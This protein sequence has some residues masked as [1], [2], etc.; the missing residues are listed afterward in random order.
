MEMQVTQSITSTATVQPC[1]NKN[2]RVEGKCKTLPGCI[3][4]AAEQTYVVNVTA[5]SI[6]EVCEKVL[7]MG[8][9]NAYKIY[10]VGNDN[11]SSD[12][13]P[14]VV[15]TS[16]DSVC[17]ECQALLVDYSQ[18]IR[19]GVSSNT[20]FFFIPSGVL[21]NTP[22]T[23]NP[24]NTP[25]LKITSSSK[26]N[27]R[28][29][30]TS[31]NLITISIASKA[32]SSGY[33]A[34]S[35]GFI[36]L[37][38]KSN[39]RTT[40]R[41]FSTSGIITASSL[42][43]VTSASGYKAKS[44]GVITIIPLEKAKGIKYNFKSSGVIKLSVKTKFGTSWH[45]VF[46]SSGTI[47]IPNI[48]FRTAVSYYRNSD[49]VKIVM[50]GSH[51]GITSPSFL[52][53]SKVKMNLIPQTRQIRRYKSS[54]S[55]SLVS[56]TKAFSA[57]L[58]SVKGQ[59]T[60]KA[61]ARTISPYYYVNSIVGLNLVSRTM[62]QSSDL[63]EMQSV[64]GLNSEAMNVLPIFARSI[65]SEALVK[66]KFITLE[67]KYCSNPIPEIITLKHNIKSCVKSF[68]DFLNLNN[69]TLSSTNNCYYKPKISGWVY[70]SHFS[71]RSID[72]NGEESWDLMISL[73]PKNNCWNIQLKLFRS[74]QISDYMT[75]LTSGF[76][77]NAVCSSS[78]GPLNFNYVVKTKTTTPHPVLR[79]ILNDEN[80][81][82]FSGSTISLLFESIGAATQ[83]S[84]Y[85]IPNELL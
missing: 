20:D 67:S 63:G 8:L 24:K 65:A 29:K 22:P 47:K 42:D 69:L 25:K 77:K 54:G 32:K 3:P 30:P 6:C 51:P 17:L 35:K 53:S 38:I 52:I 74:N 7:K 71:G 49:K 13:T 14:N 44:K 72:F 61:H 80:G 59:I 43:K 85:A 9:W 68:S 56:S 15:G 1:V 48:N 81:Y 83:F 66:R 62:S 39:A 60:I 37:S 40:V 16:G 79:T 41:R 26:S 45:P 84:S 46:S 64:F 11:C 36:N 57:L 12:V 28:I 31:A 76:N 50:G 78:F 18:E 10:E 21:P 2:Y 27:F 4:C 75:T 73:L 58:K 5:C 34:T 70:E 82:W 33:K 19:M 55:L 23:P